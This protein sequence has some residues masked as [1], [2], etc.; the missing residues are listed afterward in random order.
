MPDKIQTHLWTKK[1]A[2]LTAKDVLGQSQALLKLR[3]GVRRNCSIILFG[4]PG[5]GKT[6]SVYAIANDFDCEVAEFNT[7]ETRNK[8]AMETRLRAVAQ[9]QSLF[10]KKKIILIDDIDALDGRTDRGGISVFESFANNTVFPIIFTTSDAYDQKLSSLR[11]KCLIIEFSPV[12]QE[13]IFLK[14]QEICHKEQRNI[15]KETLMRIANNTRGDLRAAINDLQAN[16]TT[17]EE[18]KSNRDLEDEITS[19]LDTIFTHK[20]WAKVHN[21][22]DRT[23]RD[24]SECVLWIDENLPRAYNNEGLKKAYN[25]L[26]RMDV[27]RGRITRQQHWRFLVYINT[28]LTSGVALAKKGYIQER[29][30]SYAR[31]KRLLTL[32]LAKSRYAK[33]NTICEKIALQTHISI[34]KAKKSF[35]TIAFFLRDPSIQKELKMEEEEIQWLKT[36]LSF[37][38]L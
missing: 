34:K 12:T 6:S 24:T 5:T 18:D 32:W 10:K 30:I 23:S 37:P 25:C 38:P 31:P 27:F 21:I 1:Y 14:L 3:E 4:P 13:C 28:L 36:K 8:E 7:S 35:P 17:K 19:C 22:F 11:K 26:S 29:S 33:K 20:T 2:P 16:L 9:Q 15:P